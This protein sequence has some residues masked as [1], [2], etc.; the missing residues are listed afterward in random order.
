MARAARAVGTNGPDGFS[1]GLGHAALRAAL[2]S[3]FADA[4]HIDGIDADIHEIRSTFDK[5]LI[6]R[7]DI[8]IG[9]VLGLSRDFFLRWKP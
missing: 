5:M 1:F 3:K 9:P 6:S 7:T 2:V 4:Q 8:L